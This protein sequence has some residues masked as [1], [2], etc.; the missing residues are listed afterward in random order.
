MS[1]RRAWASVARLPAQAALWLLRLYR[2]AISPAIGPACRYLP[3]CSAYAEEAVGRFG[4]VRGSW[5][6]ARR[7]LRCH[8]FSRGGLDPVPPVA[9]RA[10]SSG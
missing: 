8:P 1:G 5:L 2:V 7:V 9:G 6:A 4:L 10:P 3:S